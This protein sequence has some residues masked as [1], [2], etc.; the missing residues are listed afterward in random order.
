MKKRGVFISI[1]LKLTGIVSLLLGISLGG[2][3]VLS[4]WFFSNDTDRMIRSNTFERVELLSDKIE[5]DISTRVNSARLIVSTMEGGLVYRDSDESATGALLERDGQILSLS[6]IER[7]GDSGFRA[8]L[9]SGREGPLDPEDAGAVLAGLASRLPA[10]FSGDT[11]VAN[12]S[13]ERGEPRLAIV[14]PY[15]LLD[16][17]EAESVV[18][19]EI[20]AE[21]YIAALSAREL[22]D[23]YLVD[24]T[25]QLVVHT[26]RNQIMARSSFADE[27]IVRDGL[28][29]QAFQKQMQFVGRDGSVYLGS[30]KR[31]LDGELV[32][33]SAVRKDTALAGVLL[34]QRRNILITVMILCVSMFLLLLFAKS[35]TNPLKRLVS[36]AERIGTGDFSVEIPSTSRDEI[37]RLSETFNAMT[38]GLAERDKIKSAFG[39]FVNKEIAER[40]MKGEIQL[41]GESRVAAIFFSDIRSF[42]AISE[43]L[44]PHEVVEF[45]NEYM[46]V[47]VECVNATNGVVD[48][49]IGDSIMATWGIPYSRGND[50][51]N[52]V[53]GALMMRKALARFNRNRGGPRNPIIRIGSGINTGEV[54]AG[55]IGSPERMEYTCIGDAVN[56]ASRI[57]S[58]NKVFHTDILISEYS[59]SLVRTIFRVVPMKRILVKGKEQPQQIYAVLGRY[60]DPTSFT[61]LQSLRTALGLQD[62]NL[63]AVDPDAQ[64]RKYAIID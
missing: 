52:A 62:V 11:V 18:L 42:T 22:Y 58:L 39:K 30:W 63:A 55:Q 33:V 36:G 61:S 3:T 51:E 8:V 31:F 34:L 14:F 21:P 27:E 41:G 49:F 6:V 60:D 17:N 20:L 50:T 28:E 32:V 12:I 43:R 2:L 57:E 37:G 64:E 40:V 38:K 47:M 16:E 35:L 53:N 46:T 1:G 23:N 10:A 25:G 5:T 59:W 44:T 45:L 9:S 7:D 19:A 56:L 24:S 4:T 48:K 13:P 15:R 29:G 54:I 26:D